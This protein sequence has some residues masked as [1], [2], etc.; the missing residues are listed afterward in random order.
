MEFLDY[1]TRMFG[2][3]PAQSPVYLKILTFIVP[4]VFDFLIISKLKI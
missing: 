3:D 4:V 2:M 1:F